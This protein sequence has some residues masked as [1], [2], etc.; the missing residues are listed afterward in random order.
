MTDY[1]EIYRSQKAPW[2]IGRP[3]PALAAVLDEARG[4]KVID[5]GCG[6]GELSL[7]LARR[8]HDVTGVDIS[9]V[10][11]HLARAKAEREG[12]AVRFEVQDATALS[13]TERFD[14]IFDCGLLHSLNRLGGDEL[15]RYLAQ[16]PGLAAPGAGV[17]VLVISAAAGEGWRI[18]EDFLRACF[19]DP[20]WVDTRIEGITV[21]AEWEDRHLEMPGFL[22]RTNRS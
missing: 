4:P 10:A 15:D 2:E 18:T 20:E 6:S 12:L 19:P 16:L 14:S 1:D 9:S 8:G 13:L 11:I 22:L 3:Q 7:A 21:V 17:F 5:L